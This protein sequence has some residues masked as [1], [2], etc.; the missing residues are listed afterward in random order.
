MD[1]YVDVQ[2]FQQVSTYVAPWVGYGMLISVIPWAIGYVVH[3][4]ID[5]VRGGV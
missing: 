1:Q 4:I 2:L 3:F 5:V